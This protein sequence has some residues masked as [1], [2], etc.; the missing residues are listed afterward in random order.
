MSDN[1]GRAIGTCVVGLGLL[2]FVI[3]APADPDAQPYDPAQAQAA[4]P[5]PAAREQAQSIIAQWP[6]VPQAAARRLIEKYGLPNEAADSQLTWFNNG[7]WRKTVVYRDVVRHDFPDQHL[8][9]LQQWVAYRVPPAKFDALGR[10]DGSLQIDRTAGL[11]SSKCDSE[12]RNLL[13]LNL[14]NDVVRGAKTVAEARSAFGRT[15]MMVVS[16]K[17]TPYTEG[18]LFKPDGIDTADPD[19]PIIETRAKPR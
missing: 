16:G 10:L 5:A 14:A 6:D 13:A 1:F 11:L 7:P 18:L 8:D 3:S 12:E 4:A 19:Q 15:V 2:A 17:S 9:F